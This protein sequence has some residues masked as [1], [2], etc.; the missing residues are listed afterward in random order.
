MKAPPEFRLERCKLARMDSFAAQ[1]RPHVARPAIN[2]KID[3][4]LAPGW[5]DRPRVE[6][7]IQDRSSPI[8][9]Q[10]TLPIGR[11]QLCPHRC[12]SEIGR[13]ARR[14]PIGEL[15]ARMTL[16]GRRCGRKQHEC[17]DEHLQALP[18]RRLA[19]PG[20]LS[21]RSL[22]F[23]PASAMGGGRSRAGQEKGRLF[24]DGLRP[25]FSPLRKDQSAVSSGPPTAIAVA[26]AAR[27]WTDCRKSDDCMK[28]IGFTAL[29]SSRTS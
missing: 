14:Q 26:A 7:G 21:F 4:A 12:K 19:S 8:Q 11:F 20:Q 17:C 23:H 28:G 25:V 15:R 6:M 18:H 16:R 22:Y 2:G 1:M 10:T 13:L 24:R 29:P 3:E 5:N 9:A 27:R